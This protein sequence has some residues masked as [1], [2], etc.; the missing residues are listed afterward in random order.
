MG[1]SWQTKF[2]PILSEG[3]IRTSVQQHNRTTYQMQNMALTTTIYFTPELKN[4][5]FSTLA[6]EWRA[7]YPNLFDDEDLHQTETQPQHHFHEWLAAVY[8]FHR[9]GVSAL[10]EKYHCNNHPRQVEITNRPIGEDGRAFL[11][12]AIRKELGVQ[13]PDLLLF[14]SD[15]SHF[16]F[17]EVKGP[18]DALSGKQVASHLQI[19]RRFNV[20]VEIIEARRPRTT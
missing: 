7:S 10:L 20:P 12:N 2:E 14:L 18:H 1:K 16:W 9:D 19:T 6:T 15:F 3:Q 5:W 4:R 13:P 17:A 11:W 8:L